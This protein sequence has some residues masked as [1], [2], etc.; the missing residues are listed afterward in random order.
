MKY[1]IRGAL[2]AALA[3][4]AGSALAKDA[5]LVIGNADYDHGPRAKSAERDAESV[6][7]ALGAAGYEVIAG[8]DLNRVEMRAAMDQFAAAAADADR[9]VIFYSGHAMRMQ[10]LTFLAPTDFMPVGPTAVA[11]DGAPLAGLLAL[12][13]IKPGASV[14]FLDAAQLDGFEP[15]IFAEPGI[16]DVEAPEG[17]LIVSAAA[18]GEA[19]RRSSWFSS[20]FARRIAD[21]FLAPGQ[22]VMNAA[23]ESAA[24]IWSTGALDE[25]FML[26]DAPEPEPVA[27]S[28]TTSDIAQQIELAFWRSTEAA[29]TVADYQAYLARYPEGLFAAIA[30]NRIAE[31][32]GSADASA[33]SSSSSSGASAISVPREPSPQE[34][35]ARAENSLSLSRSQRLAVQRDLT[36]LGYDTNGIDGIFGRGTRGAL[37]LWQEAEGLTV[38]GYLADGQPQIL[39]EAAQDAIDERQ[40]AA[41]ER[42]RMDAEAARQQEEDDWNRARRVN[43]EASYRRYLQAYP[44]GE[45]A[46]E[47]RLILREARERAEQD[48]WAEAARLDT[49]A[50][51][52][53]YLDK[54][55]NG[56]NAIE[57]Q[58][59][60]DNLTA[61][62]RGAATTAALQAA[63]EEAWAEA[64]DKNNI[65]GYR[66]F[67]EAYPDSRYAEE[68]ESRRAEL[69][70]A[71]WKER[72]DR[73]RLD[74]NSWKSVEQRL[75]FLGFDPGPQDGKIN[76]RT[77]NA[78][79]QYRRSRGLEV[80]GYLD[81]KFIEILVNESNQ[82]R[83]ATGGDL[84]RQLFQQLQD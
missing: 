43:T 64:Q 22:T 62:D 2:V 41:A 32:G 34:L 20:S 63:E 46:R 30:R 74:R 56:P 83:Q 12:A 3:A 49:A 16:A 35:A 13:A 18:P 60:Y 29:G 61:N 58:R 26:I 67:L 51:Y 52:S 31:G 17:V 8:I 44:E 45:Y 54:F 53:S 33:S 1:A 73:L 42:A 50:A 72:E 24:P 21:G 38:T 59:R 6:A 23:E 37:R 84:L 81:K 19:V 71:R 14:L 7:E 5:A 15:R 66:D 70:T 40:A 4:F 79:T 47:A 75:A 27:S 80:H 39:R 68:A 28:G 9:I 25:G 65:K 82:P 10:G 55:P 76:R 36:E 77:R 78:I 69:Q 57:A 11:M 48:A